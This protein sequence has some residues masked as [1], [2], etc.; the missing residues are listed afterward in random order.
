[1]AACLGMSDSFRD[2][3]QLNASGG[4]GVS[5][6]THPNRSAELPSAHGASSRLVVQGIAME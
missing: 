5:C 6:A 4:S 2:G 3:M 1:M